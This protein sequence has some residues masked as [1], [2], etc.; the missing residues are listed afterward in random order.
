MREKT[1]VHVAS[2]PQRQCRLEGGSPA[3]IVNEIYLEC[4][5]D[6]LKSQSEMVSL[7]QLRG[8]EGRAPAD[9]LGR[10]ILLVLPDW[11]K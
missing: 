8:R 4:L 11:M 9:T 1:V 10:L 6:S 5:G 7:V 3:D 2:C